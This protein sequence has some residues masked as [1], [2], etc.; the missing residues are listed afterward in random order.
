VSVRQSIASSYGSVSAAARAA[1][2][3][4]AVSMPADIPAWAL[5]A[6]A[7][8]VAVGPEL[9]AA[10][11]LTVTPDESAGLR[12]RVHPLTRAY[13]AQVVAEEADIALGRAAVAAADRGIT[14]GL[15]A[16]LAAARP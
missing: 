9:A 5:D 11:L 1:L 8:G 14:A 2:A 15:A 6:A 3:A 12:Y 4:V 7:G 16:P 10:G 13:A